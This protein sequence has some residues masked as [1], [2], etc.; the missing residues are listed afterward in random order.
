MS[1]NLE[2]EYRKMIK[3]DTPDLWSRIESELPVKKKAHVYGLHSAKIRVLAGIAA[4]VVIVCIAIP[5]SQIGRNQSEKSK[6]FV[7][8]SKWMSHSTQAADETATETNMENENSSS[9]DEAASSLPQAEDA[10]TEIDFASAATEN[11]QQDTQSEEFGEAAEGG[12]EC[13]EVG[14]LESDD[15]GETDAHEAVSAGIAAVS[16]GAHEDV[17]VSITAVGSANGEKIYTAKVLKDTKSGLSKDDV[18]TLCMDDWKEDLKAG[19]EYMVSFTISA[20]SV[21]S[22]TLSGNSASANPVA[23]R[24]QVY[25]IDKV[26]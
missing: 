11:P 20:N 8:Q 24:V 4:A 15:S 3:E 1:K 10:P 22:N 13:V 12:E 18:L 26:K 17:P 14:G 9:T 25:S 21:S 7:N 2:K 19:N 5:V 6:E 23:N 16:G